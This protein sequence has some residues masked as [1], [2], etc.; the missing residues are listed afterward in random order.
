[1]STSALAKG[2]RIGV[3][4][5]KRIRKKWSNG[6]FFTNEI[7][8]RSAQYHASPKGHMRKG[9]GGGLG[10]IRHATLITHAA[11]QHTH[12]HK[13][14]GAYFSS[15]GGADLSRSLSPESPTAPPTI[16]I[17]LNQNCLT[18]I[19]IFSPPHTILDTFK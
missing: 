16:H 10:G 15:F 12:L 19:G 4:F 1:M 17:Y 14:L 18:K 2:G 6:A 3:A 13:H 9:R 7:Y 8:T 5:V 11:A